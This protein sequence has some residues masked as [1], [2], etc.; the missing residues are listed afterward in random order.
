MF[1][2]SSGICPDTVELKPELVQ[3]RNVLL[4]D[5]PPRFFQVLYLTVQ[6]IYS[7]QPGLHLQA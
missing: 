4:Q 3:G 2:A 5:S 6:K 1:H 7:N